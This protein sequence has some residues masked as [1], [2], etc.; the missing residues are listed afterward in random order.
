MKQSLEMTRFTICPDAEGAFLA[1]RDAA[2]N[3]LRTQ[4]PGLQGATLVK[5]KSG[6]YLDLVRWT[7]HDEAQ[8][9]MEGAMDIPTVAAWFANIEA[10][11]AIEHA[12]ILHLLMA[13]S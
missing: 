6:E 5:L 7:N 4:Y 2:M 10:V 9:A 12:D 1:G 8:R 3:A 11:G 13:G